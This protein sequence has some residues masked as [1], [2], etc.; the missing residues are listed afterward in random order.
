[1]NWKAPPTREK[2]RTLL[3]SQLRPHPHRRST[4]LGIY[5]PHLIH[6]MSGMINMLSVYTSTPTI[7]AMAVA[8]SVV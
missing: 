1:M 6:K 3:R 5:M 8:A 2:E 7:S 4:I